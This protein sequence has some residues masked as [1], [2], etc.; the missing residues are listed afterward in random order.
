MRW[1]FDRDKDLPSSFMAR[2]MLSVLVFYCTG[3]EGG[4]MRMILSEVEFYGTQ[5][6]QRL[7]RWFVYFN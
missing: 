2:Q 6:N 4:L 1:L 5:K 7:S 3:I